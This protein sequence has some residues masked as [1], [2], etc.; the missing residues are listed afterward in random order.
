LKKKEEDILTGGEKI[1]DNSLRKRKT[2]GRSI[3]FLK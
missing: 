1:L 2:I 3:N